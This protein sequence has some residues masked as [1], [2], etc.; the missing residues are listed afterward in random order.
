MIGV[1]LLV[2]LAD[3]TRPVRGAALLGNWR[4]ASTQRTAP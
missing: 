4:S 1:V 3:T 2:H